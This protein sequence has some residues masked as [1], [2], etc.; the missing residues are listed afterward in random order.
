MKVLC[1]TCNAGLNVDDKKIPAGGAR[2]KC[3][4]CN[5]VFPVKPPSSAV[6]L[7]GISAAVP[8]RQD[9]EEQPTRAVPAAAAAA[10]GAVPLPG[11]S[12]APAQRQQWEE[13][14]TRAVPMPTGIPGA[15]TRVPPPSN[16]PAAG[17]AAAA[18]PGAR[19][20]APAVPLPGISAAAPQRQQWEE[21]STR[22]APQGAVPLPGLSAAPAVQ[23][24]WETES[25]RVAPQAPAARGGAVPLPGLSAAPA[26]QQPWE[27][28]ST[29]V[30]PQAPTARGGAVPLPGLSAARPQPTAHPDEA[31][32]VGGVDE[33]PEAEADSFD[34]DMADAPPPTASLPAPSD[35]EL[36]SPSGSI[37]MDSGFDDISEPPAPGA[38][39]FPP[40]P[41]V[42]AP[43][44]FDFGAPPEPEPA[45]AAVAAPGDFDFGEAPAPA[46]VAAPGDFDFGEAPAPVAEPGGFDFPEPPAPAPGGF[47]F[48]APPQS[49]PSGF[50]FAPA[51]TSSPSGDF[52][53]APPPP[54][55]RAAPM[56]SPSG[57]DF[58]APA[59]ADDLAFDFNAPPPTA[60][61]PA[62]AAPPPS[63]GDVD[64]GG[65]GDELEFDPSHAPKKADE[66][67][68][69]LSAP[70]PRAAGPSGP[71]DGLEM[72]SF[73]DDS[74]KEAGAPTAAAAAAEQASQRRFQIK[75]RSGKVFGP[76]EEAV[77]A[78]MLEDGQL[79]GNEEISV[80]GEHWQAIGIEPAF[81]QVIAQLMESP[82]RSA[83]QTGLPAVDERQKGPSMERLKQ[84]YEGRMAAVAVVQSREP[85]PLKKK[86]PFILAGAAAL[87]FLATGIFLGVGTPYGF[88]GLKKI[89]PAKVGADTR[90]FAYLKAA[91]E[92]LLKD[93][94]RSLRNARDSAAQALAVKEYPEARAVWVQAV[95]QLK[96]RYNVTEADEL[97]RAREALANIALLGEKHPEVLKADATVAL[98]DKNP[99]QA[100]TFIDEALAHQ[101]NHAD[102]EFSFL[103]AEAYLQ[104]KQ[105][106]QAKSEYE[107]ILK[108]TPTSA[109][110][111]HA[112]AGLLRAQNDPDGAAQQYTEAFAADPQHVASAVELAEMLLT[113]KKDRAHGA[114]M[115]E[116]A[117][118]D[119]A[120]KQLSPAEQ[121][122]ALALRAQ[123]L[124]LDNKVPDSV[125]IF[126]E[127]LK[128]DP[129][130]TFAK[131]L[132]GNAYL[133][134]HHPDKAVDLFAAA[135]QATPDSLDYTQGYLTCLIAVGKM[136]EATRVVAQANQRF[137][138]NAALAYLSGRVNDALDNGKEAEDAYKRAIAADPGNSDAYLYLAR[139][140]MRFRRYGDAR[141]VLETGLEKD[142]NSDGLHVGMGELAFHERDFERADTEFKKAVDLNPNS[143][144]AELGLSRVALER[145]KFDLA[146]AHIDKALELNPRLP[147]GRLQKGTALW[148]L[149]RLDEAI[150]E[151]NQAKE[152]EPRNTLIT[153]TL[154]AVE[155]EK[156]EQNAALQH[157][158]SALTSEPGNPDANFYMGR[159]K[160]ARAEH[161]QAIEAMKRAIDA[162]SKEPSYHY[163]MG[164]ILRD[165]LKLDDAVAEW[166]TTLQLEPKNADA[167]EAM[168][169]VFF[170]RND[171]RK[172]IDYYQQVLALD[173]SRNTVRAAVGD[174]QVKLDNWDGAIQSYL[175]AI[176]ADPD[177]KSAYLPLA[178]AY[179]AKGRKKEALVWFKKT[180]DIDDTNYEAWQQLGGL[181]REQ[182]KLKE[183]VEAYQKFLEVAPKDSKARKE[184]D[185]NIFDIQ[186]DMKSK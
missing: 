61:I 170:D 173:P 13:E 165:D 122:K 10:G 142:A 101:D 48:A 95:N 120:K 155:F 52:G 181:Y 50:D 90:E 132:L 99:D 57:F 121:A 103:R 58:N 98:T 72:L 71:A 185:D 102:P 65:G 81:Q 139:F 169:H 162:N 3:P 69:D 78:K 12:A 114:E 47:D 180:T 156:G 64:L 158:S 94:Y 145:A 149:N 67:E 32:R 140:Y 87:L 105:Q 166:Q 25:T 83:T 23:Q 119:E 86:I 11:L 4:T 183:A 106:G 144:E 63:F 116:A 20:S 41:A 35:F 125:P 73:I 167:L 160:N 182:H 154:G 147:G 153:V 128:S 75:R 159:L 45:P 44:A 19:P 130:N 31:T 70:L 163:W 186:Q 178:Q 124:V 108:A 15:T 43:G 143:A 117:L 111:H 112:L 84:L 115:T 85:I 107:Q 2:I 7:P 6:P 21:E 131:A 150:T 76:F 133:L 127:A 164:I 157:L 24:P 17:P 174:A 53:F 1:P 175:S 134:T 79:L 91:R 49:A 161:T 36:S 77:I 46:P 177:L 118:A 113:L 89:F 51:P 110:A 148:R 179:L 82:A 28:E 68:A 80:D 26:V 74:A 56:S 152:E 126:Q 9:W 60:A 62:P 27:T 16:V 33:V 137:P 39:D 8:Q 104:K 109:R 54:P 29:R 146:A 22:V 5:N 66:F 59:P 176:E 42:A 30:A 14:S 100:L 172:A 97:D 184:V 37:P 34:F 38:F 141:P 151:L 92:G 135:Y 129:T 136:D 18:R 123:L 93:T 168:A 88:F 40:P 171:M 96:R 55:P 138:G